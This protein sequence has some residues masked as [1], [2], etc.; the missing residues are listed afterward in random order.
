MSHSLGPHGLTP[1]VSSVRGIFQTRILSGFPFPPPRDLPDP[2][3][4]K[5]SLVSPQQLIKLPGLIHYYSD[6]VFSKEALVY[7][8]LY[9]SPLK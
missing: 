3:I 1:P 4:E 9:I 7:S 6:L 5:G 2:R 8:T